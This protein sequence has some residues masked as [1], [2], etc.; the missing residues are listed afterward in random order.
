MVQN[1]TKW[2]IRPTFLDPAMGAVQARRATLAGDCPENHTN[3]NAEQTMLPVKKKSRMRTRT[4]RAHHALKPVTLSPC[5][6]CGKAK[7]PHAACGC[8]YVSGKLVLPTEEAEG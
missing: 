3:G 5:P 8:G 4:R 6:R 2:G 1:L 7:L